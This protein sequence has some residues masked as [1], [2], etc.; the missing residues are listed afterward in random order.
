MEEHVRLWVTIMHVYI[1][2][3]G[4]T[5]TAHAV[6]KVFLLV[7][8]GSDEMINFELMTSFT[9]VLD[10]CDVLFTLLVELYYYY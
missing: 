9:V 5:G 10:P 1:I 7:R 2:M 4:D 6:F 3:W 8:R